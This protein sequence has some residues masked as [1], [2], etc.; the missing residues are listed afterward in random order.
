MSSDSYQYSP[1]QYTGAVCK[2]HQTDNE[3]RRDMIDPSGKINERV[4]NAHVDDL[5]EELF[6]KASVKTK[7]V[8]SMLRMSS[9]H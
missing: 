2:S 7:L 1:E 6:A 4:I 8:D 5:V 3:L 9:G